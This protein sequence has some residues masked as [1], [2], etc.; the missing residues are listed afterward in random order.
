QRPSDVCAAIKNHCLGAAS[1]Q[2][3]A[4]SG[5]WY[6]VECDSGARLRVMEWDRSVPHIGREQHQSS[7]DRLHCPAD[8]IVQLHRERWLAEFYPALA[9][10]F[11]LH[12]FGKADI[13][14]GADPAGRM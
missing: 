10:S 14:A 1:F 4:L 6:D 12:R 2:R 13:V 11:V 5:N 7:R 8:G 9:G 3:D